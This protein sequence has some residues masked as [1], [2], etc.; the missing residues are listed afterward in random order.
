MTTE[1][2][3][4]Q[5][6]SGHTIPMEINR[7]LNPGSKLPRDLFVLLRQTHRIHTGWNFTTIRQLS[8]GPGVERTNMSGDDSVARQCAP[9]CNSFD[10][11][12]WSD[13]LPN[14]SSC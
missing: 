13:H 10:D 7:G 9:V 4:P 1:S 12:Q 8:S 11:E 6:P 2:V 5:G 14:P 3:R